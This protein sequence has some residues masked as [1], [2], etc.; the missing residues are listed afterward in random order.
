M[1]TAG[2]TRVLH[3]WRQVRERSGTGQEMVSEFSLADKPYHIQNYRHSVI[4]DFQ[5]IVVVIEVWY[6]YTYD[7]HQTRSNVE[8]VPGRD[9]STFS[10]LGCFIAFAIGDKQ[11]SYQCSSGPR[12][13]RTCGV[14]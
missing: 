13:S 4:D 5:S 3:I 2:N 1:E 9:I 6:P 8:N 12:V 14:I 11:Q 10:F 7:H